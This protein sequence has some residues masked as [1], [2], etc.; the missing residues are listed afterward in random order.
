MGMIT[1]KMNDEKTYLCLNPN[2]KTKQ[3][4]SQEAKNKNMKCAN[5]YLL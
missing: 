1:M 4:K 5:K 3:N 2:T